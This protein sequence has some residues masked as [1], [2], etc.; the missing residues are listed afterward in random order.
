MPE[1]MVYSYTSG[2]HTLDFCAMRAV[3]SS[4][5]FK[6]TFSVGPHSSVAANVERSLKNFVEVPIDADVAGREVAARPSDPH[7]CRREEV[8]LTISHVDKVQISLQAVSQNHGENF[9]QLLEAND[10]QYGA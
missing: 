5:V 2:G 4:A 3:S 10:H 1:T 9:T 6:L 8:W 7:T